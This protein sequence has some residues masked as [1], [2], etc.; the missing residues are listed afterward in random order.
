MPLLTRLYHRWDCK[1]SLLFHAHIP[2][3][4]RVAVPLCVLGDVALFIQSNMDPRA[5]SVM[6]K[7]ITDAKTI[8]VGSVFDFGLGSTVVD[9]W[10]AGVYPLAVLILFFSGAW[11][12]VKLLSMLTAWLAPPKLLSIERRETVLTVLDVLGK[13]SLIDFFVMIL[14]LCAFYFNIYIGQILTIEVRVDL[15]C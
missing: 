13:W 1:S 8:D 12:Y 5:V 10:N 14:M 3:W 6:V 7:I 9:M 2:L 4:I 11:P 15:F